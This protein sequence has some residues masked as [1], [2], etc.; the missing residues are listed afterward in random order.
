MRIS[1]RKHL[2]LTTDLF[3]ANL[4]YPLSQEGGSES[5]RSRDHLINRD[6]TMMDMVDH[7]QTLLPIMISRDFMNVEV[8]MLYKYL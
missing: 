3:D 4:A 5:G 1:G 6:D 2:K 8:K 7:I